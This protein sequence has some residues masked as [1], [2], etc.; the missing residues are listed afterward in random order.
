MARQQLCE[1]VNSVVWHCLGANLA[2]TF[3]EASDST[4]AGF[5]TPAELETE[6]E[7]VGLLV[8]A[9]NESSVRTEALQ[10]L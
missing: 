5:L 3:Q 7:R 4:S 1:I 6:L 9:S 10:Q 8:L 2:P